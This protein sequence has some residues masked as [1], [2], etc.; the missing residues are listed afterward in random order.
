[1]AFPASFFS[2]SMAYAIITFLISLTFLGIATYTDLKKR[3]VPDTLSYGI[4]GTGILLN[5]AVSLI[6]NDF[7]FIIT[8]MGAGIV[9]FILSYGLWKLGVWAGG[10]VK[11]FTAIGFLS[12]LNP[13]LLYT[14][15]IIPLKTIAPHA[16]PLFPLT[17]FIFS[18]FALFP[19]AIAMSARILLKKKNKTH[20]VLHVLQQ[21]LIRAVVWGL[22][23]AALNRFLIEFKI[24]LLGGLPL[25]V[26]FGAFPKKAKYALA[27]IGLIAGIVYNTDIL[28]TALI[29]VASILA[30]S[31]ITAGYAV[32]KRALSEEKK[33]SELKEGDIVGE[34]IMR[35][36]EGVKRVPP[37]TLSRILSFV[38]SGNTDELKHELQPTGSVIVSHRAARGVDEHELEELRSLVTN[39][40]LEDH[41]RVKK[42]IPFV[43][44]V[45]IAYVALNIL[46]DVLWN[47][48]M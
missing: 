7:S 3:I 28:F 38:R 15:G 19:V 25:M 46:G 29:L 13:A 34:S 31:L 10:D 33:I 5:F 35:E 41:I 42:S 1:M 6:Q 23:I 45:L 40:K 2:I 36:K 9:T 24:P 8:S 11:L 44:A 20:T 37:L 32:T 30:L 21:T 48:I 17:L 4:M 26:V 14:L 39:K 47:V 27:G 12:P 22:V 18:L 16:L 43:P